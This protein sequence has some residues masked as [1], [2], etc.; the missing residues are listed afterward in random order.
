MLRSDQNPFSPLLFVENPTH[1]S[2][3]VHPFFSPSSKPLYLSHSTVLKPFSNSV[4]GIHPTVSQIRDMA[5]DIFLICGSWVI[6][7]FRDMWT[8]NDISNM[9]HEIHGE[10]IPPNRPA[11]TYQHFPPCPVCG[12]KDR[13]VRAGTRESA[14]GR[15]H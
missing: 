12:K 10:T 3:L 6:D 8:K 5:P 1:L 2:H 13:I 11:S 15:V 14:T 9:V 4:H 7:H